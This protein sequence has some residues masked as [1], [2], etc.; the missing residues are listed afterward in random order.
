MNLEGFTDYIIALSKPITA[1]KLATAK[2]D[3]Q[4]AGG[5]I[6]HVISLGLEGFAVSLPSDQ[7]TAFDQKEY[8]DFIEQDK[9]GTIISCKSWHQ[10]NSI[11]LFV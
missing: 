9:S 1:E 2:A 4:K 6:N 3:I 10:L 7:V 5:K 11:C 8:V